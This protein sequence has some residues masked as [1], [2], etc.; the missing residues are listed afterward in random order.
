MVVYSALVLI[1]TLPLLEII[2]SKGPIYAKTL[3][4]SSASCVVLIILYTK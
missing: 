2:L 1:N 4:R 3:N